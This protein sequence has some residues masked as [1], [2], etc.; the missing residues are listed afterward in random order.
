MYLLLHL[1]L[2]HFGKCW[3][4]EGREAKFS[5]WLKIRFMAIFTGISTAY[6]FM[7]LILKY[8]QRNIKIGQD[9]V[10]FRKIGTCAKFWNFGFIP[11]MVEAKL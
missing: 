6:Q 5:N 1:P 8:Y 4:A 10:E 7:V 11:K 9:F 3:A 2:E